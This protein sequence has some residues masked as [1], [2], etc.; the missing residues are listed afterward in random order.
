MTVKAQASS[1][2]LG[3]EKGS[4]MFRD[5]RWDPFHVFDQDLN[6]WNGLIPPG[7]SSHWPRKTEQT[8][9]RHCI[10]SRPKIEGTCLDGGSTGT[11][12]VSASSA[13]NQYFTQ[14]TLKKTL[15]VSNKCI[16]LEHLG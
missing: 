8:A 13:F 12:E 5:V 14:Q 9:I 15:Y 16:G 4:K 1:L 10:I 3:R 7:K 6:A 11:A 2:C